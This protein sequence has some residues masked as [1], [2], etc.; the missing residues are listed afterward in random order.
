MKDTIDKNFERKFFNKANETD[1]RNSVSKF[2]SI[3]YNSRKLYENYI[4]MEC[5]GKNVLEYGC[6][7]GSYAFSLAQKGALITG[8]DI[9][10]YA[11]K[12]ACEKA[13]RENL[14]NIKFL[15]MDAENTSFEN[16]SFD[17]ICGTGI[18]HHLD[19]KKASSQIS[20]I[21][22]KDGQAVFIEPMGY[23]PIINIYRKLTPKLRTKDEHPLK[24]KDI[25][26]MKEYFNFLDIKFF[27]LFSIFSLIFKNRVG[28]E[29]Y[30]N[31]FDNLDQFLFNMLPFTKYLSWQ[32]VILLKHPKSD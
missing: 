10:D 9:A 27:H 26:I 24:I 5:S 18:L 28:F 19:I 15:V 32:A 6:G 17:L 30:V 13:K 4:F 31:Y 11:I 29:K 1:V 14:N 2:Y 22:K 3:V 23:N 8:I 21:L 16:N 12:I 7:P 25:K 20:R